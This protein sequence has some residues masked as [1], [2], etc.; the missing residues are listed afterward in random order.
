MPFIIRR[1]GPEVI[2]LHVFT[3]STQLNM[4]E[5]HKKYNTVKRTFLALKLICCIFSAMPNILC[6]VT[7]MGRINLCLAE[8]SMTKVS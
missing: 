1:P 5:F 3:C 2:K 7:L 8:L 4:Y 6:I